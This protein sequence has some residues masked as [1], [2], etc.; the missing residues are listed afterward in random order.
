M[1]FI[2]QRPIARATLDK[3]EALE[4]YGFK[5]KNDNWGWGGWSTDGMS[6]CLILHED[7]VMDGAEFG[8]LMVNILTLQDKQ[9]D[10]LGYHD[11]VDM[12]EAMKRGSTAYA[13]IATKGR[14]E[15]LGKIY[16]R[17]YQITA[18]LTTAP[19]HHDAILELMQ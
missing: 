7:D 16:A 4:A 10:R 13:L 3:V 8:S 9:S 14:G 17:L 1:Q 11:R 6:V 15:K 2:T 19:H 5:A 18:I 12:L